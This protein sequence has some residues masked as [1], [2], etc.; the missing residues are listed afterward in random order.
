M[1]RAAATTSVARLVPVLSSGCD[2]TTDALRT[3]QRQRNLSG[4]TASAVAVSYTHLRA[5]ETPEH[6]VCRLLLEKKNNPG[7]VQGVFKDANRPADD[8]EAFSPQLVP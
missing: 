4:L 3:T 7:V 5:H 6:L 2:V 8:E 1:Q